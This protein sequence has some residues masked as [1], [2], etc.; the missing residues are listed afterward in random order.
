MARV[1]IPVLD[2][3]EPLFLG[4]RDHDAVAQER[5]GRVVK[6]ERNAEN[7]HDDDWLRSGSRRQPSYCI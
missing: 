4:G 2:P 5:G 1:G 6:T 3:R 7:V